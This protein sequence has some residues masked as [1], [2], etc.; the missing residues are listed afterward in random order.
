MMQMATAACSTS[1]L[2]TVGTDIEN[3]YTKTCNSRGCTCGSCT[4]V[5]SGTLA[6]A[7]PLQVRG[8][9]VLSVDGRRHVLACVNW[10]LG[11]QVSCSLGISFS[12]LMVHSV[13]CRRRR[14]AVVSQCVYIVDSNLISTDGPGHIVDIGEHGWPKALWLRCHSRFVQVRSPHGDAGEQWA[15]CEIAR[16]GC[17]SHRGVEVQLRSLAV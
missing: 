12:H 5:M 13:G 17:P 15:Q 3:H 1:E 10:H 4:D 14:S 6:A 2:G 9:H 11:Q 8:S 16:R 7:R